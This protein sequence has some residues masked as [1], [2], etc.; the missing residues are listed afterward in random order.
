MERRYS[1]HPQDSKHYTTEELRKHYLIEKIFE[2]DNVCLTYSHADRII[3]GGVMPVNRELKLEAGKELGVNYF[4]E[5]RELALINIGQEGEVI[6]DGVPYK[7]KKYDG[8]YVGMGTKDIIL[9]STDKNSPAKFYLAS[10]PAHRTCQTVHIDFEKSS[11]TPVGS[12]EN[13]NKRV[14]NKYIN[15]DIL[16]TC[17]LQMG[18]TQLA[19]NNMWNTMPC[20]THD[21]RMEVYFYFDMGEEDRVFHLMGEPNETRHI[22]MANEQA[23]ISPSWSIHSGVGTK[24]Y[25]F[26]WAMCGENQI[27]DDMDAIKVTKL[28]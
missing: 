4:L 19:P 24:K 16:E 2:E 7:M 1:N 27:Y 18:M 25:S 23:V 15:P 26:I 10:S 21:R 12:D 22:I 13:S 14:I 17:Q 6:L 8:L 3:F 5:R 9:K 11:H 28:K 20:H